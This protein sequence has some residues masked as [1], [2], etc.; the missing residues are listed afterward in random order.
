MNTRVHSVRYDAAHGAFEG[1]VDVERDGR[2]FRY[3]ARVEAPE[4][5]PRDWLEAALTRHALRMSD[6]N[7]SSVRLH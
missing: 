7:R 1:R 4:G 6:S 2:T 3:P 5:A